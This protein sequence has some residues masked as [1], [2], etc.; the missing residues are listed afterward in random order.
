[1]ELARSGLGSGQEGKAGE[2][3]ARGSD[4]RPENW[5]GSPGGG[6][7]GWSEGPVGEPRGAF[8]SPGSQ[9]QG[10]RVERRAL[11]SR[12]GDITSRASR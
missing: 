1:M 10:F 12:S 4:F 11:E 6:D 7:R 3:E 5:T 9:M 8:F 2:E